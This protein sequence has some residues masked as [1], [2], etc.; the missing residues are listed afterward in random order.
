MP[1][2][3]LQIATKVPRRPSDVNSPG[4][5]FNNCLDLVNLYITANIAAII[6]LKINTP[7]PSRIGDKVDK[8]P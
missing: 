2:N 6:K 8:R 3:E 5:L 4:R 1:P 7:V